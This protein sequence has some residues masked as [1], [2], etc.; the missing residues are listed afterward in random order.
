MPPPVEKHP[1][2]WLFLATAVL[3][4]DG[5]YTCLFCL[6]M[7]TAYIV[8]YCT[9]HHR[10]ITVMVTKISHPKAGRMN[11]LSHW[12]RIWTAQAPD[13]DSQVVWAARH[14]M[15]AEVMRRFW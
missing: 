13:L 9:I 4:N 15:P 2:M 7:K 10:K 6:R 12:V 3:K 11:F 8:H 5:K 1:I 14:M